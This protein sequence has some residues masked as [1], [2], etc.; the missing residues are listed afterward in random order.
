MEKNNANEIKRQYDSKIAQETINETGVSEEEIKAFF[1]SIDEILS[2]KR[3]PR[4]FTAI[5]NT[6]EAKIKEKPLLLT[7]SGLRPEDRGAC[8]LLRLVKILSGLIDSPF[9]GSSINEIESEEDRKAR[10]INFLEEM[11]LTFFNPSIAANL[12]AG[13]SPDYDGDTFFHI[14]TKNRIFNKI[15]NI[16]I[17]HLTTNKKSAEIL[18]KFNSKKESL[19]GNLYDNVELNDQLKELLAEVLNLNSSQNNDIN[20]KTLLEWSKE[21]R[22]K[23]LKPLTD[24]LQKL[25]KEFSILNFLLKEID[26]YAPSAKADQNGVRKKFVSDLGQKMQ[27]LFS[28]K[29]SELKLNCVE[30]QAWL[31]KL[32]AD[33]DKSDIF[34]S[35]SFFSHFWH[36]TSNTEAFANRALEILKKLYQAQLEFF[37]S[38]YA[39]NNLPPLD[40]NDKENYENNNLTQ[41]SN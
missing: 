22:S 17:N 3:G 19:I 38:D 36:V 30:I 26:V 10:Q 6:V 35:T 9:D 7:V 18:I 14:V 29:I 16:F 13:L 25:A 15:S 8:C 41:M 23:N 27:R 2:P 1:K 28:I 33:P 24:F 37:N 39:K 32:I 4:Q 11:V 21:E 12:D 31:N 40:K 34:T 20:I 5:K